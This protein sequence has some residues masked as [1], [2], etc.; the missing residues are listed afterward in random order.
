M[1][2]VGTPGVRRCRRGL[3][4]RTPR[5]PGRVDRRRLRSGGPDQGDRTW[6]SARA[7]GCSHALLARGFEVGRRRTRREHDPS[8][9]AAGWPRSGRPGPTEGGSRTWRYRSARS[10]RCFPRPRFTGSSPRSAGRA[11]AHLLK[12]GGVL[13]LLQYCEVSDPGT[14]DDWRALEA[15]LARV[16][17]EI[18]ARMPELRDADTVRSGAAERATTSPRCGHG[19]A[20]TS[21]RPRGRPSLR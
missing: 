16:A 14:V 1:S 6:R 12:P 19:S 21:Y 4:P 2:G 11:P 7:P 17:P 8:R 15:A 3:R 13:A 9:Q 20:I 5:L 10:V 18:G